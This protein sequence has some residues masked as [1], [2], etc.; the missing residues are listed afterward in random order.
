M[1]I[2]AGNWQGGHRGSIMIGTAGPD[3]FREFMRGTLVRN[4]SNTPTG[5]AVI[6][7]A[8]GENSG[9]DLIR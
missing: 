7:Q 4:V 8:G 1:T 3:S 5:T 9:D 6:T 2:W